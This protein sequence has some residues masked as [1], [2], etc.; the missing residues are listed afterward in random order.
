MET[1]TVS[2]KFLSLL[3]G[4]F[5]ISFSVFVFEISLLS[6]FSIIVQYHMVFAVISIAICGIGMGGFGVYALVKRWPRLVEASWFLFS[7]PSL[8]SISIVLVIVV[9]FS[10]PLRNDWLFYMI[11]S[12]VPFFFAGAFLAL[13]FRSHPRE[14]GKIYFADLAGA[15]TGCL[16]VLL[17]LH[18]FGGIGAP[19]FLA[20]LAALGAAAVAYGFSRKINVAASLVLSAL[21]FAFFAANHQKKFIDVDFARMG[22]DVNTMSKM[23]QN[24][25]LRKFQPVV[26]Y[27]TWDAYARTDVVRWVYNDYMRELYINC[28]T[29]A[30]MAKFDGDW[31]KLDYLTKQLNFFPFYFS[32]GD[33]LLNIGSGGGYEVLQALLAGTLQV[34]AVD[35]NPGVVNTTLKFSDYNGNIYRYRNVHPV[36]DDGRSFTKRTGDRYDHI[37]LSLTS[38]VAN[39]KKGGLRFREDYLHSVDAFFDYLARLTDRGQISL[40]THEKVF[41]DKML[42]TGIL[43]LQRHGV[44]EKDAARH[45]IGI[46][47]NQPDPSLGYR[48]LFMMRKTPYTEEEARAVLALAQELSFDPYFIPIV[49]ENPPFDAISAGKKTVA[50]LVMLHPGNI[51]PS[52]DDKPFFFNEKRGIPSEFTRL[53]LAVGVLTILFLAWVLLRTKRSRVRTPPYIAYFAS[54]GIGFIVIEN[55]LIQQFLLFLGY[56]T[57]SLSV[58]IF[59]LLV[60]GSLG[61]LVSNLFLKERLSRG[62]GV[63]AL[64]IAF[65]S[66]LYR[67]IIP[68]VM[69]SFLA[70]DIF[71]RSLIT[72]ALISPLG[73]LMGIPFPTGI[74]MLSERGPEEVPSMWGINGLTSVLGSIG[75]MILAM[76][77]GFAV[78]L[79]AGSLFYLWIGLF[80]PKWVSVQER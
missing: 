72:M 7:L 20:P 79:M 49:A 5:I 26:M 19:L 63:V 42:L 74:R 14:G 34:T 43:A 78:T 37:L 28:G 36:V 17:L 80:F 33:H 57:L 16:V 48:Y 31:K 60:S 29:Q 40:I 56:P 45:I 23:L 65:I 47:N 66:F 69:E 50:E 32:G 13:I 15:S 52:S 53:I 58:I 62:V 11:L 67:W 71:V 51:E 27:S 2:R 12:M 21:L 44:S 8:F 30:A 61:S 1:Q 68:P 3:V 77:A 39:V 59:S 75:A 24:P 35:I 76:T 38:T 18:Y 64:A 54:L 9:I 55:C 22:E 46:I 25:Q 41:L 70:Q 73:F 10:L 6:I 4:V